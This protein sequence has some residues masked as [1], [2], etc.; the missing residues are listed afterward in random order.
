MPLVRDG[1][2]KLERFHLKTYTA[3]QLKKMMEVI[4]EGISLERFQAV[5]RSGLIHDIFHSDAQIANRL[6]VRRALGLG[7]LT[8]TPGSHIVDYSLD[9]EAMIAAGNYDWKNN[10]ITSER[11]PIVGEGQMEFEDTLFHFDRDISS[12]E[13]LAEI[14]KADPKN[15]WLP[16][17]AENTLAYGA[18]NPEEQWEYPIIGLGSVA[19][20]DGNRHV[21]NLYRDGSKRGLILSW[22]DDDWLAYYRFL[23]GS[24]TGRQT[25]A[26]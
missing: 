8:S 21:L 13:A 16:A 14:A 1:E 20:V 11:F 5:L 6:A 22:F 17:K 9:L 15:P 24:G 3:D 23:A 25:S 10:E 4:P 26:P 19:E 12:D 2:F 18:K 7:A